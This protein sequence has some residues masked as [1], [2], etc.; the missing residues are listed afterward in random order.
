MKTVILFV[1]LLGLTVRGV[2]AVSENLYFFVTKN[3]PTC[4]V[5]E[6]MQTGTL[7]VKYKHEDYKT[8]PAQLKLSLKGRVV[9]SESLSDKEG[10]FAYAAIETGVYKLCVE[11]EEK[12]TVSF[13]I[14]AQAKV[15]IQTQVLANTVENEANTQLPS[16]AKSKQVISLQQELDKV[17]EILELLL[18]KL[19]M[20][21]DRETY[22]R[23]TSERIN[24]RVVWW[25]IAQTIFLIV[26]GSFQAL[27][28]HNFF[29]QKKI[30]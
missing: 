6:L 22:F 17:S 9:K 18:R 16:V 2:Q 29:L 3:E 28:L 8:K 11:A 14:M 20:A 13:P 24:E 4:F 12:S 26:A 21:R 19:Q 25:S 30:A 27:N 10:R 5:D 7:L 23:D 1:C 15:F